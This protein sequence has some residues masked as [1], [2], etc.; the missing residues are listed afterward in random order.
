M[1]SESADRRAN[2]LHWP[3]EGLHILSAGRLCHLGALSLLCK[4]LCLPKINRLTWQLPLRNPQPASVLPFAPVCPPSPPL[5]PTILKTHPSTW[6]L[7]CS[8]QREAYRQCLALPILCT[9]TSWASEPCALGLSHERL[10]ATW[11]IVGAAYSR[12][13]RHLG[14]CSAC[15]VFK[16]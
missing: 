2:S 12:P 4:G 16:S 5:K 7:L 13:T 15:V 8:W 1:S 14:N 9:S 6:V 3:Q 11:D 10:P